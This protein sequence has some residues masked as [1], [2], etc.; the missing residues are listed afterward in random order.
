M[1]P[2]LT[3]RRRAF[4]GGVALGRFVWDVFAGFFCIYGDEG[5][6]V[7]MSV[8]NQAEELNSRAERLLDF[9]DTNKEF[10]GMD[11]VRYCWATAEVKKAMATVHSLDSYLVKNVPPI[12]NGIFIVSLH[13]CLR[14]VVLYADSLKFDNESLSALSIPV[15][16]EILKDLVLFLEM[17]EPN[18]MMPAVFKPIATSINGVI[19]THIATNDH[20]AKALLNLFAA[21]GTILTSV[22]ADAS[23]PNEHTFMTAVGEILKA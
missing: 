20:T 23:Y 21:I 5:G 14:E 12:S 11:M 17:M 10:L 13:A 16:D 15:A 4:C 9:M 19:K 7:D 1:P 8:I 18:A 2:A 6:A 22:T 3:G